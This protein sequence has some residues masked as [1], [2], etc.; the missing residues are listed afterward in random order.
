[1]ANSLYFAGY[2]AVLGRHYPETGIVSIGAS[3]LLPSL[4]GAAAALWLSRYTR[5]P[6]AVFVAVTLTITGLS[7]LSVLSPNLGDGTP[8]PAGFDGLVLPMHVVVGVSAA[9][10]VSRALGEA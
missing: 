9:W 5:R 8:K 6:G 2:E 7:L 4:L 3:S 1:V 10:A